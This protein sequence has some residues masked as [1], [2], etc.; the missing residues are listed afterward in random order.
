MQDGISAPSTDCLG[1]AK[2]CSRSS[3]ANA[4]E[5]G[6]VTRRGADLDGSI[7]E[8]GK[9]IGRIDSIVTASCIHI[10]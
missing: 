3:Y 8:L 9:D 4:A 7:T 1:D 10:L 5:P 6:D 2:I